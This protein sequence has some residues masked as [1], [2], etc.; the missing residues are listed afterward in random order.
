MLLGEELRAVVAARL[1]VDDAHDEQVAVGRA[2]AVAS[3]ARS[4]R[5]PRPRPATSCRARRG[6][7]RA[8]SA[9]SPL[10][11]SRCHSSGGR[12]HGVDVAEVGR[13]SA[14][15]HAPFR[16]ATRFGRLS[17]LAPQLS[18]LESGA[19]ELA[20]RNSIAGRS[21][22]GGFTVSKRSSSRGASTASCW[23]FDP[24]TRRILPD[25]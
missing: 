5:R 7:T 1:L 24:F 20:R 11:G 16:R 15:A 3:R 19:F 17:S 4:P 18:A 23:R 9:T 14:P 8:P 12:E 13:A 25:R 21:S 10:H 6:P 22:P 2:P